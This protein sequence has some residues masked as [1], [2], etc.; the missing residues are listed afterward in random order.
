VSAADRRE[1]ARARLELVVRRQLSATWAAGVR[2]AA[3]AQEDGS[4][5]D[6]AGLAVYQIE[7]DRI[8]E[9]TARAIVRQALDLA[10]ATALAG[11]PS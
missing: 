9:G 7:R 8:I 2:A 3:D 1:A 10:T 5:S 6:A 4:T 11:R